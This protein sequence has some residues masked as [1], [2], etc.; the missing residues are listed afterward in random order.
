M[1]NSKFIINVLKGWGMQCD[2]EYE[3]D[4]VELFVEK[5]PEKSII[6]DVFPYVIQDG[7]KYDQVSV[8][9]KKLKDGDIS[10]KEYLYL[11]N[12]YVDFIKL[13]S[14]YNEIDISFNLCYS[15]YF[16]KNLSKRKD[17]KYTEKTTL[18]NEVNLNKIAYLLRLALR[19][20]GF[21]WIHFKE[22]GLLA[23]IHD[24]SIRLIAKNESCFEKLPP[25]LTNSS[26][27][28]LKN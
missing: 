9:Y 20:A 12:K 16:L 27:Y 5:N 18:I 4:N 14:L 6:I 7:C 11:E 3:A 24:F 10:K 17:L 8:F 28:I 22:W 1:E 2:V 23:I 21:L 19:E 25:I 15:N 13:L 26:L